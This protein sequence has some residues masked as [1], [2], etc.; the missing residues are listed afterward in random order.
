VKQQ[1][2]NA[3]KIRVVH[4]RDRCRRSSAH[5]HI[6]NQEIGVPEDKRNGT[7]EVSKSRRNWD[8]PSRRMRG[9]HQHTGDKPRW[10]SA[11]RTGVRHLGRVGNQDIGDP[12]YIGFMH[13]RI[14][15]R[16]FPIGSG[17]SIVR[18]RVRGSRGVGVRHIEV[19]EYIE[20]LAT[21]N[22][23]PRF[24]DKIGTV[25]SVDTW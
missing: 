10:E 1:G 17:P 2:R 18:T 4:L 8:R 13:S 21:R 22:R 9:K 25:H 19:F 11:W 7:L 12:G 5:R 15:K 23:D 3:D 24:T 20:T 16:D 6:V 14:T